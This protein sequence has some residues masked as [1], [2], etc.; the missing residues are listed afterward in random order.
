MLNLKNN[1]KQSKVI[2]IKKQLVAAIGG[3]QSVGQMGEGGQK[4]KIKKNNFQ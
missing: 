2:D 4:A 1:T 3:G